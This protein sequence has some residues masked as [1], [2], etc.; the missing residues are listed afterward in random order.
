MGTQISFTPLLGALSDGP[1]AYA[2]EVDGRKLVL[3]CGWSDAYSTAAMAPLLQ[4]CPS[5]S[6]VHVANLQPHWQALLHTHALTAAHRLHACILHACMSRIVGA[7]AG[8]Q[9]C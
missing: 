3:D 2:L 1:L 8:C 7:A 5:S 9:G 6:A 4:A